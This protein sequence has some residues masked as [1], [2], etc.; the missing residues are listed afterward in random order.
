MGSISWQ[1][2]S[3]VA[4]KGKSGELVQEEGLYICDDGC[5]RRYYQPGQPFLTCAV[6]DGDTMWVKVEEQ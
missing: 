3:V 1:G 6:T 4:C 2:G 5:E